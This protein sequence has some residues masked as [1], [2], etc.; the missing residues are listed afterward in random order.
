MPDGMDLVLTGRDAQPGLIERADIVSEVREI[1][2]PY[3]E[4]ETGQRRWW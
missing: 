4:G 3:Q 2:H 1:K